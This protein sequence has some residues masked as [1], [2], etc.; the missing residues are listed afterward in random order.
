[1]AA[2]ETRT[3]NREYLQRSVKVPTYS[4]QPLHRQPRYPRG[5]YEYTSREHLLG[6]GSMAG[7]QQPRKH[8]HPPCFFNLI[9]GKKGTYTALRSCVY[10]NSDGYASV[11]P[12]HVNTK[13]HASA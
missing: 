2:Y 3:D 12:R 7:R 13:A 10:L 8:M 9:Y 1:M 4:V 11:C 6:S 5:V